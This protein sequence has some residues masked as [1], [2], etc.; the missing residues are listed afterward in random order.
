MLGPCCCA[1]A[2]P[3]QLIATMK[4][5]EQRLIQLNTNV[6]IGLIQKMIVYKN[7]SKVRDRKSK[8]RGRWLEE[9]GPS[10]DWAWD[11]VML[12]LD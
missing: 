3:A 9:G 7:S 6:P 4:Q 12:A 1:N 10:L 5:T 2:T 8:R 11:E